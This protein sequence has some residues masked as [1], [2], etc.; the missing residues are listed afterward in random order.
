MNSLM[1]SGLS[2]EELV[3]LQEIVQYIEST[4]VYFDF[5]IE[6]FESLYEKV[7]TS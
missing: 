3:L 2:Y 1:I 6:T 5:D 4:G 7:M